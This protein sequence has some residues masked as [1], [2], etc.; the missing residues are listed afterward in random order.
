MKTAAAANDES[1]IIEQQQVT[2]ETAA[3]KDVAEVLK[4]KHAATTVAITNE[5]TENTGATCSCNCN[6][7]GRDDRL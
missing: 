7:Q 1:E 3:A 6:V 4:Q 5:E 2:R